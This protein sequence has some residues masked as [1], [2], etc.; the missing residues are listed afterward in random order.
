MVDARAYLSRNG[1]DRKRFPSF[2]SQVFSGLL[3]TTL[4]VQTPAMGS[5]SVLAKD[6]SIGLRTI[7]AKAETIKTV[8]SLIS[9]DF[10]VPERVRKVAV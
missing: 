6:P 4:F 2:K 1:P 7:N 9:F 8:T 3:E 10:C 5:Y